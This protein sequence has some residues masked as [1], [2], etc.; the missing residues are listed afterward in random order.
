VLNLEEDMVGEVVEEDESMP[1][2]QKHDVLCVL[3]LKLDIE[4][5]KQNQE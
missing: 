1:L 4:Y 2:Q 3:E 5:V